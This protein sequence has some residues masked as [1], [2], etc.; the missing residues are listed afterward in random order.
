[1]RKLISSH[2]RNNWRRQTSDGKIC[3]AE[4]WPNTEHR[5]C[6]MAGSPDYLATEQI[7]A[8]LAVVNGTI[9]A[10]QNEES[11]PANIKE[12]RRLER[13]VSQVLNATSRRRLQADEVNAISAKTTA[14]ETLA[15]DLLPLPHV[16]SGLRDSCMS[17]ISLLARTTGEYGNKERRFAVEVL[18]ELDSSKP[19]NDETF[20]KLYVQIRQRSDSLR[21]ARLL[22]LQRAHRLMSQLWMR[23]AAAI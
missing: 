16:L 6:C 11:D 10:D 12:A 23:T 17:V 5:D 15:L 22:V 14:I 19:I 21:S 3:L 2:N 1:M 4:S 8:R 13:E 20:R 18:K 9:G 7:S